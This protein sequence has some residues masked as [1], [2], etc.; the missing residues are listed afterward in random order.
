MVK[1]DFEF[2]PEL[3]FFDIQDKHPDFPLKDY[4][5]YAMEHGTAAP[6]EASITRRIVG[7]VLSIVGDKVELLQSPAFV[8]DY[9]YAVPYKFR[10]KF[11][12][13]WNAYAEY[14][15][16]VHGFEIARTEN[17]GKVRMSNPEA[18][19]LIHIAQEGMLDFA[20]S[21]TFEEFIPIAS[22]EVAA[23]A[24][25]Y[26][27]YRNKRMPTPHDLVFGIDEN[28]RQC[29]PIWRL[30]SMIGREIDN[31]SYKV[32]ASLGKILDMLIGSYANGEVVR[33]IGQMMLDR[34]DRIYRRPYY[35]LEKMV[36]DISEEH[37]ML[38]TG[39]V[40]QLSF[41]GRVRF[42]L[43]KNYRLDSKGMK[44]GEGD[45]KKRVKLGTTKEDVGFVVPVRK[46][47]VVTQHVPQDP[48]VRID[49]MESERVEKVPFAV[50]EMLTR[51]DYLAE[52]N[53]KGKEKKEAPAK[54]P[55]EETE[56]N[57]LVKKISD[58]G[59]V[60]RPIIKDRFMEESMGMLDALD[61]GD[62]VMGISGDEND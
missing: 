39:G 20:H 24:S 23:I 19:Y 15:K 43:E 25:A 26:F 12:V 41:Q 58:I 27:V 30:A 8:T 46:H 37:A 51:K 9:R 10:P 42:W 22:K 53:R 3:Y 44:I 4:C 48:E 47:A 17:L 38:M 56:N 60:I 59:A 34:K 14:A 33:E 52:D 6:S 36:G 35:Y 57:D 32:P 18:C 5:A 13:C 2:H 16:K 40:S 1:D 31:R 45:Y 11:S 55:E 61:Q 62:E 49:N 50:I 28:N 7:H 21:S 29:L 54:K